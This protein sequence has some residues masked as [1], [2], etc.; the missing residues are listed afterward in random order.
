MKPGARAPIRVALDSRGI[1][2]V[3]HRMGAVAIVKP[4]GGKALRHH[5]V[6]TAAG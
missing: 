6:L 5:V 1:F 4:A 3:R 2:A